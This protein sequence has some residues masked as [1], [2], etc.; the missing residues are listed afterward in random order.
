[1]KIECTLTSGTGQCGKRN[2]RGPSQKKIG[3]ILCQKSVNLF[4]AEEAKRLM[5]PGDLEAPIFY[6][7]NVLHTAKHEKITSDYFDS[8]PI[9]ALQILKTTA[10]GKNV[11]HNI[12]QDPFYVIYF[13]SHQI[14]VYK[15]LLKE[16]EH[17]ALCI[18][19]SG[20]KIPRLNRPNGTSLYFSVS[21]S[22]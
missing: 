2:L 22:N 7:A 8:D 1:M 9:K 19:A 11:V 12:G 10:L 13:T 18:D 17:I 20:V 15:Q 3:K 16:L 5:S 14:Q 4:R 6:K 21:C